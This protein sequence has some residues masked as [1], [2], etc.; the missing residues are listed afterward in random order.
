MIHEEA[1]NFPSYW[2]S[3]EGEARKCS[4]HAEDARR[5]LNI[6]GTN[7]EVK[8]KMMETEW[9]RIVISAN[10]ILFQGK[11]IPSQKQRKWMKDTAIELNKPVLNA[12]TMRQLEEQ[13]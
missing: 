1:H 5:F 8:T 10:A 7:S 4:D 12:D 6:T 13:Q 3:K 9:F 2:L 11:H